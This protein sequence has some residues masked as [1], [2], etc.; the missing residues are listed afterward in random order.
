MA[1][2]PQTP[3]PNHPQFS[4]FA[5]RDLLRS[6]LRRAGFPAVWACVHVCIEPQNVYSCVRTHARVF[7][8][9]V[10]ILTHALKSDNQLKKEL[11]FP[12]VVLTLCVG[13]G[14]ITAALS[15][16]LRGSCPAVPQVL[17]SPGGVWLTRPLAPGRQHPVVARA[18]PWQA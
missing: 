3:P 4:V 16:V 13:S 9:C 6:V 1:F 7:T 14:H 2:S 10:C 15:E 18:P 17:L 11:L 8:V 12:K 5:P